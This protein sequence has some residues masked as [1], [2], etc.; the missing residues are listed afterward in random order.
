MKHV[1]LFES[2]LNESVKKDETNKSVKSIKKE[3]KEGEDNDPIEDE[4]NKLFKELVPSNGHADTFEGELV[5]AIMRIWYRY[6][7]DGDYYFRGYGIETCGSS[8]AF[9][10]NAHIRH[11]EIPKGLSVS[12]VAA[13]R[14]AGKPD[15]DDEYTDKD[16][17]LNN[18]KGAAA[19]VI[20][21][22]NSR[23]GKYEKNTESSR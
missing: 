9:L 7:N 15:N 17:Y 18:L 4:L 5:R 11:P 2:F 22:V 8:A 12:L 23:N 6:F 16:D 21:Y 3:V 1:K 20:K 13:Q 19:E 10:K 14:E